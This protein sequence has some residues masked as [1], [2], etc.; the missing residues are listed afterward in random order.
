MH[1][2]LSLWLS[3]LRI[4]L[5][6][7]RPGFNPWVGK[8]SWRREWLPIPVFLPGEFHGQRSLAGYSPWS[9]KGWTRLNDLHTHRR[10]LDTF[11][12][13]GDMGQEREP[14][15]FSQFRKAEADD[16]STLPRQYDF[17]VCCPWLSLNCHPI[18]SYPC[19][20]EF[21]MELKVS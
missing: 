3:W 7:W 4:H 13:N 2:R 5:Q 16:E 6:W 19:E 20:T 9:H 1:S 21:I 14:Q 8:I 17:V 18:H 15:K 10:S 11:W 12:E